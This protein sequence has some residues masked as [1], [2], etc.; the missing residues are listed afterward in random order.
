[1]KKPKYYTQPHFMGGKMVLAKNVPD[2][3]YSIYCEEDNPCSSKYFK[4][5]EHENSLCL[6]YAQLKKHFN[7]FGARKEASAALRIIKKAYR[8]ELK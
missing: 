3:Y 6:T 8:G 1:M 2:S 5:L 4:V 7:A